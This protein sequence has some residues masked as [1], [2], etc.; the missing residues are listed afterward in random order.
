MLRNLEEKQTIFLRL[1][2]MLNFQ[3]AGHYMQWINL[4]VLYVVM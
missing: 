1:V 2:N 3:G 4:A